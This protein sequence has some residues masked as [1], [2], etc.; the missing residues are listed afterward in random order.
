MNRLPTIIKHG[1][2]KLIE[3]YFKIHFSWPVWWYVINRKPRALFAANRPILNTVQKRIVG[4]LNEQGIAITSLQELFPK[5]PNLLSELQAYADTLNK[6]KEDED[7]SLVKPF[8]R[9]LWDKTPTLTLANPFHRL[10]LDPKIIDVANSYIGM[11]TNFYILMLNVTVPVGHDAKTIISQRWHRDHEDKKLCKLFLYLNDVDEQ[12]GPFIYVPYSKYETKWGT[13]FPQQVPKG[14]YPR[15]GEVEKIIP[16][17]EI[18]KMTGMAG[19]L[20]WCDTSGLH[21]GGHAFSKERLMLTAGYRTRAS[22]SPDKIIKTG[23]SLDKMP[24]SVHYALTSR[25][26]IPISRIMF[27]AY[28]NLRDKR[29]KKM[30]MD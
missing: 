14:V 3:V 23:I 17:G 30:E 2:R 1:L 9:Y 22:A 20:L 19:T 4:D 27:E 24:P 15:D 10:V 18:K 13:I 5:Q 29:E 25:V 8:L 7:V 6:R 21:K 11:F 26:P 12:A 28:R 16:A